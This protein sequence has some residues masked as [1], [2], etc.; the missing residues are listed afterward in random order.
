MIVIG[1]TG[2][3]SDLPQK[4]DT[5]ISSVDSNIS[6]SSFIFKVGDE[7][8]MSI[9][10]SVSFTK[11]DFLNSAEEICL[12]VSTEAKWNMLEKCSPIIGGK[13]PDIKLSLPNGQ[14]RIVLLAKNN[15]SNIG[16]SNSKIITIDS[17]S[18]NSEVVYM[19]NITQ[20]FS[21]NKYFNIYDSTNEI[22]FS[23]YKKI[24]LV[25]E[26]YSVFRD[27]NDKYFYKYIDQINTSFYIEKNISYEM[28]CLDSDCRYLSNDL[29]LLNNS[30]IDF[31]KLE[32]VSM[33]NVIPDSVCNLNY[34]Q[35]FENKINVDYG[36]PYIENL[37]ISDCNK[38]VNVEVILSNY[39][40]LELY[41]NSWNSNFEIN[42]TNGI[43]TTSII[44]L[45]ES[46]YI[47]F[48]YNNTSA[49]P[50]YKVYKPVMK[51]ILTD[52]D[53]GEIVQEENFNLTNFSFYKEEGKKESLDDILSLLLGDYDSVN[54]N[55]G[56]S[57]VQSDDGP[58]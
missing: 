34:D 15:A 30:D 19:G 26:N 51:V 8:D 5:N 45:K 7:P 32:K 54:K 36:Y 4:E 11:D 2:C 10:R 46:K 58:K 47:S 44:D 56:G 16:Q 39:D 53:T 22:D 29:D 12:Q 23:V 55:G 13:Y 14:Y 20:F 25:N 28:I 50:L 6:K 31:S 38:G 24:T 9:K 27:E 52:P 42:S 40:E 49:T 57:V 33:K 17:I 43:I 37:T 1:F 35:Y 41:S 18:S 3:K 21:V 48:S